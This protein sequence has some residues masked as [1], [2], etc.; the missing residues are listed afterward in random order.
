MTQRGEI[1]LPPDKEA[2]VNK[3]VR[4][5]WWS[6]AAQLSILVVLGLTM[7]SSQ[8]L[9]AMWL[10]DI[11]SI[12]PTIAV[13][14]GVYV[15]KWQPDENF[16]YGY[17]RASEI[18]FMAGAVALFGFGLFLFGDS[19]FK[20]VTAERPTIATVDAFGSPIWMGWFMIAALVYSSVP[21]FILGRLKTPIATELHDKAM[22]V[23]ATIDK[24]DW[25]SG[26]AAIVGIFGIALGY[27]WADALAGAFISYEIINDGWQALKNSTFQLMDMHPTTVDE[28]EPDEIIEKVKKEVEST[29]W[30]RDSSVR[31]REMGDL[32]SGEAFVVPDD[33]ASL[34]EKLGEAGERIKSLDWRIQDFNFIPVSS[35]EPGGNNGRNGSSPRRD[36]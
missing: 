1:H 29:P 3:A 22:Y 9:K 26:L 32:I 33:E 18:G 34:L 16:N 20:L 8:A 30:V 28:K 25:L 7:G 6:L 36:I 11:L 5:E 21:P 19:L 35:L 27:W 12:V 15:S 23:S 2:L 31:L 24:G 14:S 4:I 17:R 10:E 13:L